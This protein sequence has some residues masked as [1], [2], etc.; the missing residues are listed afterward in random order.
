MAEI[1]MPA[2]R[3][4]DL[5]L[6]KDPQWESYYLSAV[7]TSDEQD[8]LYEIRIP[9][10]EL[11]VRFGMP[12]IIISMACGCE[13]ERTIDLGFGE[14]TMPKPFIKKLIKSKVREMTMADI[15]KELGCK[16]KIVSEDK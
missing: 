4:K 10:I 13:V 8:G 9:R 3:L 14:L 15:E 1:F 12:D 5:Q 7:Y 2:Y 6:H 16:V 11:P